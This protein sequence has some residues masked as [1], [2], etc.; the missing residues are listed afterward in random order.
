MFASMMTVETGYPDLDCLGH[1]TASNH[2]GNVK[3]LCALD[4]ESS[5]SDQSQVPLS[6][7]KHVVQA[8]I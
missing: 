3:R 6:V 8:R 7:S 5:F 4:H 1:E 2:F